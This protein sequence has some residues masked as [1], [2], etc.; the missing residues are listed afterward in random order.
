MKDK[1]SRNA[2]RRK[3]NSSGTTSV[4][5]HT[6]KKTKCTYWLAR[7]HNLDGKRICK[8]FS[9]MKLG[10]QEAYS[11][12]NQWREEQILLLN[13]HGAGYTDRHGT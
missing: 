13:A 6:D 10:Y 11:L 4:R 5:L 3:D 12:A 7:I 2:K 1:N 8:Y 9:V